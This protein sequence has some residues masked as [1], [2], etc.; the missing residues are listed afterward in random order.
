LNSAQKR[1][2]CWLPS[3]IL[4]D[5]GF[6]LFVNMSQSRLELYDQTLNYT[7]S[8]YLHQQLP[9]RNFEKLRFLEV[10]FSTGI[11][12]KSDPGLPAIYLGFAF[13]ILSSFLSYVSFSE[14]WFLTSPLE[15]SF[16]GKTNRAKIKFQIQMAKIKK[17]FGSE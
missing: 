11:Q 2:V 6:F 14:I 10:M 3:T 4:K 9:Q 7:S 8:M 12:I 13:L 5:H 15:I 16:G 17:T 1:W